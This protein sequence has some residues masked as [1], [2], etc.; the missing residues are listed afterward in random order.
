MNPLGMPI[1]TFLF[2][3]ETDVLESARVAAATVDQAWVMLNA[4]IGAAKRPPG[5]IVNMS[6]RADTDDAKFLSVIR[7]SDRAQLADADGKIA[8]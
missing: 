8:A 2:T 1:F 4:A 6:G 3:R 7:R 5:V